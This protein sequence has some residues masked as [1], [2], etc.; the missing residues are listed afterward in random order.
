MTQT[1]ELGN[2]PVAICSRKLNNTEQSYFT[3]ERQLSAILYALRTWWSYLHGS[4]F[5]V[6]TNHHPL[7]YLD[8]QKTLSRK[9][10]RWVEFLGDF[11]YSLYSTLKE[12]KMLSHM[13]F[14]SNMIKY[15]TWRLTILET[16]IPHNHFCQKTITTKIK[17]R[18]WTRLKPE[19]HNFQTCKFLQKNRKQTLLEW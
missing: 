9:Q 17:T 11:N 3:H 14:P 18:I 8:S 10:A 1:D 13:L 6:L 7:N 4:K 2:R 5:R 15:V 12:S 19:I 16:T